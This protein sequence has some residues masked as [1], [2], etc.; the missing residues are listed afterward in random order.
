M[1]TGE[2]NHGRAELG[3]EFCS[4]T[5]GERPF[6]VAPAATTMRAGAARSAWVSGR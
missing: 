3:G 4:A 2:L 5:V 6:D 1:V